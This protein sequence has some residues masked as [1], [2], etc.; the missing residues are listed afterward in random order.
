MLKKGWQ[1]LPRSFCHLVVLSALNPG[2][3]LLTGI[4][5]FVTTT[6]SEKGKL[7]RKTGTQSYGPTAE[8]P[9]QPGCRRRLE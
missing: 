4:Q 3:K 5:N 7:A 1:E 6:L 8:T 2:S 9:W